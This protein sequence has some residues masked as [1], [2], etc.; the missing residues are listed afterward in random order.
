M[1]VYGT[2]REIILVTCE[3]TSQWD[4]LHARGGPTTRRPARS[5]AAC[6]VDVVRSVCRSSGDYVFPGAL[7]V[8]ACDD[9]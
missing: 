1:S 7:T 8:P 6:R 9:Q 4:Q 5:G 2:D 3:T